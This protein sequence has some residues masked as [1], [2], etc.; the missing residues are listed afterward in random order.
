MIFAVILFFV[1]LAW[2]FLRAS[3]KKKKN[4]VQSFYFLSCL[5][6]G[7][8]AEEAN[9]LAHNLLTSGSDP[10]KNKRVARLASDYSQEKYN[11][12]QLPVIQE[13]A[14]KGFIV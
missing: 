9:G 14:S 7:K 12:R 2:V 6:N 3:K 11:G 13:A 10:K 1:L 8:T 5:E 4:F